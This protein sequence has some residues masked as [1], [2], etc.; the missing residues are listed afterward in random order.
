MQDG[1]VPLYLLTVT[2]AIVVRPFII[3]LPHHHNV[4]RII[5][6]L[7]Q[8]DAT[9]IGIYSQCHVPLG[10]WSCGHVQCIPIIITHI[11]FLTLTWPLFRK[12]GHGVVY[13]LVVPNTRALMLEELFEP[14]IQAICL[15]EYT[16]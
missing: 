13:I 6:T 5:N 9:T 11:E 8:L 12:R 4:S 15:F 14:V 7:G 3:V 10:K 1:L 16:H 2:I